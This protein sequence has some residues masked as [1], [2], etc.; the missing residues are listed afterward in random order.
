MYVVPE[1][2]VYTR[3]VGSGERRT[4]WVVLG[5]LAVLPLCFLDQQRLAFSSSLSIAVNLYVFV[6]IAAH[7]I[8]EPWS[9]PPACFFGSR[10]SRHPDS[11]R[12]EIS[13]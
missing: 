3:C 6:L 2:V 13:T 1:S 10:N 8:T 5:S 7:S 12:W 11:R 4:T 9:G